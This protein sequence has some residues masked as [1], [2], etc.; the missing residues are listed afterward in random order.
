[1]KKLMD[2]VL[3]RYGTD[4]ELS[5]TA[6]RRKVKVFFSSINS[7]SWQN[8]QRVFSPLG[9]VPQGQYIC[10]LPAD[11]HAAAEDT[12]RIGDRVFLLRR[13]EPMDVLGETV[14]SWCLCVE[15]GDEDRWGMNE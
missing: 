10:V 5:G 3:R 13:I 9:E 12:L 11:I 14:Y 4:A 15:K 1:M 8:M 7:T 2:S 6:G